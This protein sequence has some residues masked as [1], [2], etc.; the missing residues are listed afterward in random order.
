MREIL[1]RGKC[2]DSG[3]WVEGGYYCEKIGEYI[4][5]TFIAENLTSQV[6]GHERVD[7]KTVGQFT[8]LTDKNGN[9]IFEGDIVKLSNGGFGFIQY[10]SGMFRL[11][12][13]TE[14]KPCVGNINDRIEV[15]G[16]IHDNPELLSG[17]GNAD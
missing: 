9:K 5:A 7:H 2:K 12:G 6:I 15:V 4:T 14:V 1:F 8:G 10:D 16:N 11:V 13:K 17:D 3:E